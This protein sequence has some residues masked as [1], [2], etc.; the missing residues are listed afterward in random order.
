MLVAMV[1]ANLWNSASVISE[2][3]IFIVFFLAISQSFG[4]GMVFGL[5]PTFIDFQIEILQIQKTFV[6][7]T[8]FLAKKHKKIKTISMPTN[9]NAPT[10]IF[11]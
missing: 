9:Q 8:F 7:F 10:C 6:E 2:V 1:W 4:Y 5:H 3:S 11:D